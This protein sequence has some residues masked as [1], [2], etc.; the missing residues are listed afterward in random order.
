[1]KSD[2]HKLKSFYANKKKIKA[3]KH[4]LKKS[5]RK[6][7]SFKMDFSCQSKP[8]SPPTMVLA[9]PPPQEATMA[10]PQMTGM[11]PRRL[12]L[13]AMGMYIHLNTRY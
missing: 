2:V 12:I 11:V 13:S 9:D 10:R 5:S 1:M 3:A 7:I 6:L 8:L 4:L